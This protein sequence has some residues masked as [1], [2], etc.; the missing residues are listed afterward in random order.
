VEVQGNPDIRPGA[1]VNVKHVGVYSGR[2]LVTE[3]NHFYDAAGS[4][5]SSTSRA[6]SLGHRRPQQAAKLKPKTVTP[7]DGWWDIRLVD[8]G[9]KPIAG[10]RYQVTLPD[11]PRGGVRRRRRT[12]ASRRAAA[13]QLQG[14]V[15]A[16]L[17]RHLGQGLRSSST[18]KT[19][20]PRVWLEPVATSKGVAASFA[21]RIAGLPVGKKLT[22]EFF[23]VDPPAGE[24]RRE[25]RPAIGRRATRQRG[26]QGAHHILAT[27][28]TGV[29]SFTLV[30]EAPP[31]SAPA[32]DKEVVEF[33]FP[34]NEDSFKFAIP[35]EALDV[36]EGDY[37]EIQVRA[38]AP[39]IRLADPDDRARAARPGQY[40][41]P[42]AGTRATRCSPSTTARRTP[43]AIKVRSPN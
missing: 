22:L 30:P 31:P 24:A 18:M 15:P 5:A 14:F 6:T 17:V 43:T 37:W 3:A 34:G 29:P 10:E 7:Q 19:P 23:E 33:R 36:D 11:G 1:M 8:D 26:G 28:L 4:T 41:S 32:A 35:N 25:A 9:G 42:I 38:Q 13:R 20:S 16:A 40:V 2:Y 39:K 21:V 27:K 12:R